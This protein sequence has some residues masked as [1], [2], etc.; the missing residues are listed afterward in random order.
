MRVFLVE[1]MV[2]EGCSAAVEKAV[3][4]RDPAAR[5]SVDLA[6]G[7]ISV[8]SALG[9]GE[10]AAAIAAAGFTAQRQA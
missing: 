6:S 5:L 8:D 4:G 3:T 2:C 1:K 9:D 7:T 10:I